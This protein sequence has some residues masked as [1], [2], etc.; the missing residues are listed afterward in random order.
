M[1]GG[2]WGPRYF[3]RLDCGLLGTAHITA[4]LPIS[5]AC[6][7]VHRIASSGRTSLQPAPR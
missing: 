7:V 1:I 6:T 5:T 2:R 3:T 4:P